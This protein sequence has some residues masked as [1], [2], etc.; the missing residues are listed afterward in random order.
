MARSSTS[1]A[2]GKRKG[3]RFELKVRDDLLERG[4][5]VVRSAGS[6]GAAD[7]WAARI[8]EEERVAADLW[9]VQAKVSGKIPP[10]EREA[11]W[12]L[13]E[14]TGGNPVLALRPRRGVIEYRRL[15]ALKGRGGTWATL[16]VPEKTT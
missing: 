5:G 7:L 2:G 9:L 10:T 6:G 13:A 16:I 8:D 14:R 15:S 1:G 4:F 11:L 12:E 3:T